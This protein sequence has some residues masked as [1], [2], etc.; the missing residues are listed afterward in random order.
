MKSIKQ[1]IKLSAAAL[2]LMVLSAP[3]LAAET[4]IGTVDMRAVLAAAPQA[5]AVQQKLQNEFKSREDKIVALE[6]SVKEKSEKMQRNAAVMSEAE[7]NKLEKE[8]MTSQ[9]ELQRLQNDFREDANMRQQE[10]M[11]QLI[12]NINDV[13]KDVAQKE[14]YDLILHVDAAPFSSKQVDVTDKVIKAVSNG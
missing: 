1:T 14:K 3:A 2:G 12:D 8:I 9:R 13:I 10:E 5:K 4:K 6:K 11:K 7:K